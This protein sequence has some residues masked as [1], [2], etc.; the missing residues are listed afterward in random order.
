MKLLLVP[1]VVVFV[2]ALGVCNILV[3][4]SSQFAILP[5]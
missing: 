4:L 1:V 2:F 5:P 3:S